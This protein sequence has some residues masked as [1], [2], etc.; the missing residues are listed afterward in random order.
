MEEVQE[1]IVETNY[2]ITKHCEERYAE[3]ILKKDNMNDINRFIAEN[4]N[5]IHT[6]VNKMI[7]YGTLIF[8]GK[9]SQKDG[10]GNVLSVYVKDTWIIL[11]DIKAGKVVTLF[12]VDLGCGDEFNTLYVDKMMEKLINKKEELTTI[13]IEVEAENILNTQAMNDMQA[14]INEY[15]NIIK[16]LEASCQGYQLLIDNNR[17]KISQKNIEIAEIV[18]TLVGKK[19]F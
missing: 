10:K 2:Q 18:N 19:E 16:Q 12:K 8:Q 15:K 1:E 11:V 4:K 13:Q 6:D 17:V 5:K 3:R 9:Q 7:T 14:Q